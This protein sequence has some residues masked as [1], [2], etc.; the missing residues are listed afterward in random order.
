MSRCP[1][2][3]FGWC[4]RRA[5]G[6]LKCRRCGRPWREKTLWDASWLDGRV[7]TELIQRFVWGVPVY[8]QRFSLAAGRPATE[9]FYPLIRMALAYAEQLRDPFSLECDDTTFGGVGK[10]KRGWGAAGEVI[11]FG[12]V[13]RNGLVKAQAIPAHDRASIMEA[14]QAGSREG[15]LCYTDEWPAWAP[16]GSEAAMS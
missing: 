9:R 16:C 12:I 14:I 2:C 5:D 8:R 10:G 6:R 1:D 11:V 7:K 3:G 13:K 4:W 15:S